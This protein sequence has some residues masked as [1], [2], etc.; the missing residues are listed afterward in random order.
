M[1]KSTI[2]QRLLDQKHITVE[3]AMTLMQHDIVPVVM[4]QYSTYPNPKFWRNTSSGND[5]SKTTL[6]D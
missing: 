5:A 2:I 4:P 6:N 3:E 1:K